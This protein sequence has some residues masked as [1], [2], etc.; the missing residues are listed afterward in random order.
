MR[1]YALLA[2]ASCILL[3]ACTMLPAAA[4]DGLK[5]RI[6]AVGELNRPDLPGSESMGGITWISNSIYWAVT[7]WKPVVWELD[8][9]VDPATGK[10][11]GCTMRKLCRPADAIDV[12]GIA[13]DPLDGSMWIA[14]ERAGS[15]KRHDPW[16]GEVTGTME[17]PGIMK[18]TYKDL[19]IESLTIS[20]GGLAMWI[21]AEAALQCD[22]PYA[23]RTDGTDV[24]LMR[25]ARTAADA[26][27]R[28]VGQWVY[29]TDSIVGGSWYN[30]RKEDLSRCGVAEL[31]ALDDGMLLVLER[32]FSKVM[33]P[34]LRC[35]IYEVDLS[36]ATDVQGLESITN[37][38]SLKRAEKRLLF[39]TTGFSMYEG[40]CLG[41]RLEDGSRL[42]V[43]VSDGD[44]RSLRSVMSLRL[45]RKQGR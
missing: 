13:R 27:W 4:A 42:L 28:I 35:R 44:K 26:P 17:L 34:R 36:Y 21:C 10:L 15:V 29:H 5:W 20:D 40:M 1:R 11:N 43:L 41:P 31:C 37:T 24:R 14:D 39:E 7:D 25:F 33:F 3:P 8:M 9:P 18:N 45:Y 19:G 16:T 30:N 22:G 23:T 2:I 32:E 6:E 38:P 12:E